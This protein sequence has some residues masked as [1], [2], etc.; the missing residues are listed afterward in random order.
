MSSCFSASYSSGHLV[1]GQTR[2]S[3]SFGSTLSAGWSADIGGL[4]FCPAYYP[5]PRLR[6]RAGRGHCG[7]NAWASVEH[8]LATS[9]VNG[10]G[11]NYCR[12]VS[13]DVLLLA[14]SIAVTAIRISARVFRS[15]ASRSACF[16][17]ASYGDIIAS[18]FTK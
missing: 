4:Q 14:S 9:P 1:T 13:P 10:G 11:Q 17:A 3:R 7:R 6:G 15:G 16:S 5:L 12:G 8:L 2:I 18:A